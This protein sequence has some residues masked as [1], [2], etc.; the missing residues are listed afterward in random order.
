M[1]LSELSLIAIKSMLT[2]LEPV[3]DEL[4][5]CLEA[6]PRRQVKALAERIRRRREQAQAE[7]RVLERMLER[8]R[9]FHQRGSGKSSFRIGA[10][11]RGKQEDERGSLRRIETHDESGRTA[12]YRH[13][14]MQHALRFEQLQG[15]SRR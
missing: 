11:L 10:N 14:L 8:E 9:S 5:G 13:M 15:S 2:D 3:P 4:L 1:D 6:D 12:N 7:A